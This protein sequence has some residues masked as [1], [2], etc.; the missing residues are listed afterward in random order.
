[1]IYT[2]KCLLESKRVD[3]YYSWI[4][5]LVKILAMA[6]ISILLLSGCS[7]KSNYAVRQDSMSTKYVSDGH[8]ISIQSDN[9]LAAG[10]DEN[11][12]I[13]T[14][15]FL[16]GYTYEYYNV[17]AQI[18]SSFIAAQPHPWSAV[19]YPQLVKGGFQYRRIG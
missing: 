15:Q 10:Y 18:W 16:N 5:N 8:L 4:I 17:P 2:R 7:T 6:F 19:G 9:V 11:S 12:M 1:M 14:V 13:M 3:A